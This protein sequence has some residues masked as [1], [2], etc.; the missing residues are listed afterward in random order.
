LFN[1]VALGVEVVE[2]EEEEEEEEGGWG[3]RTSA[4]TCINI[5]ELRSFF[6]ALVWPRVFNLWRYMKYKGSRRGI[7]VSHFPILHY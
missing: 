1:S 7:I 3:G 5:G 6:P 2:A 4:L